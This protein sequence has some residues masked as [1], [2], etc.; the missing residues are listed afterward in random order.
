MSTIITTINFTKSPTGKMEIVQGDAS[1]NALSYLGALH[2]TANYMEDGT[3]EK[4]RVNKVYNYATDKDGLD[5][6]INLADRTID[7]LCYYIE[8]I[9]ILLARESRENSEISLAIKNAGWLLAGLGEMTAGISQ[10]KINMQ[11]ALDQID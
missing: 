9:G 7:S 6:M 10:V 4:G 11:R 2:L 1:L 8:G 3:D 5:T